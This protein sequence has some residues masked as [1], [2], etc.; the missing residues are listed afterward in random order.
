MNEDVLRGQGQ[1]K[2]LLFS[3]VFDSFH[4]LYKIFNNLFFW[5]YLLSIQYI[6]ETALIAPFIE[7]VK[8]SLGFE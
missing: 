7:H 5:Q 2:I 3:D 6:S 1:I 4:N 8:I